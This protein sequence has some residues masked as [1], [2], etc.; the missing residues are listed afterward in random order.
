M[1]VPATATPGRPIAI[2]EN[3]HCDVECELGYRL[4]ANTLKCAEQGNSLNYS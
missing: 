3:A 1:P 4:T 2:A